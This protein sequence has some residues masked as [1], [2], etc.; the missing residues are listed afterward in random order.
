MYQVVTLDAYV[1]QWIT[2]QTSNV[3]RNLKIAG[4]IPAVGYIGHIVTFITVPEWSNGQALRA[5]ISISQVRILPV[6]K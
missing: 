2:R 4:S 6:I 5:C 3:R 1:A